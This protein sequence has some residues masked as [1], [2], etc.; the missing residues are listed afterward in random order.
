MTTFKKASSRTKKLNN[1]PQKE[2]YLKDS[3]DYDEKS[4]TTYKK[5]QFAALPFNQNQDDL[6]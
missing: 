3:K 4:T 1:P 6:V 5:G 2:T